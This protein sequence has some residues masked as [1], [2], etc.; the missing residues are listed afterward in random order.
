MDVLSAALSESG[1]DEFLSA[2]NSP[3]DTHEHDD[4]T[5]ST[6]LHRPPRPSPNT[7]ASTAPSLPSRSTAQTNVKANVA[8]PA[9]IGG[10]VLSASKPTPIS[11]G[12][13]SNVVRQS[14]GRMVGGK[15]GVYSTPP[16]TAGMAGRPFNGASP[17]KT[18]RIVVVRQATPS[19]SY[20][21]VALV[22]LTVCS[23][24]RYCICG[25]SCADGN[26]VYDERRRRTDDAAGEI[27]RSRRCGARSSADQRCHA[28]GRHSTAHL[29][30]PN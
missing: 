22:E 12:Q 27:Q 2:P 17:T 30:S 7:A 29:R 26:S 25:T 14:T 5:A 13:L 1:L 21:T 23:T 3:A 16:R 24:I 11:R 9:R 20:C 10:A 15:T 6:S 19:G 28:H 8:A 4:Q 18:Q